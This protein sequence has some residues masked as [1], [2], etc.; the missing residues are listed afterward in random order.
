MEHGGEDVTVTVER[1]EDGFYVEDDGPGIPE[2]ER[3]DVFDSG[4]TTTA[5]GTGFGLAIVADIADAHGWTLRVAEAESGGARFE[6]TNV[7]VRDGAA[8]GQ[9][10]E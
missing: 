2:S 8:D 10:A 7:G 6:L 9:R 1:L 5:D 3:G 4:Y